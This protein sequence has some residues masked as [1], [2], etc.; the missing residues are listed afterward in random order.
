[1]PNREH[2]RV[3]DTAGA[4][5]PVA[6]K[7]RNPALHEVRPITSDGPHREPALG[8]GVVRPEGRWFA[9]RLRSNREYTVRDALERVG[10]ESFLPTWW[11]DVKWSDRAKRA[12]RLLF[13]GYIFVR[14]AEGPMFYAALM[15]RGVVQLLPTSHKPSPIPDSEIDAV[16]RVVAHKLHVTPCEFAT[17]DRVLVES[18]PF[19]GV[20][21]IVRRTR[22][23]MHVVV[24]VEMLRRSVRVELD[25]DT[26][27][28]AAA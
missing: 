14:L 6:L 5:P 3:T 16:R 23:E 1:M 13:P 11:E 22:G 10:I 2:D 21:G 26:L 28:K 20:C 8:E 27:V 19:A 12:E 25:A 24:N 15:V 7:R 17:G 4:H 9:L 18:G